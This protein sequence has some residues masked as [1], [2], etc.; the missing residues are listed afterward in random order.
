MN[1]FLDVK[2]VKYRCVKAYLDIQLEGA[3][4]QRKDGE[5]IVEDPEY[6]RNV[7]LDI[8]KKFKDSKCTYDDIARFAKISPYYFYY[9]NQINKVIKKHFA[10]G[11]GYIPAFLVLETLR[12]YKEKGYKDFEYLEIEKLQSMFESFSLNDKEHRAVINKHYACA[13][14]LVNKITDYKMFKKVKRRNTNKN[15]KTKQKK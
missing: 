7:F 15:K 12:L 14:D 13:Y 5:I 11:D 1:F 6:M 3:E 9:Y 10:I 8:R 4:D 2:A